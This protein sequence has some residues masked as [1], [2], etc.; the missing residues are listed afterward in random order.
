MFALT[1][2]QPWALWICHF[3]K[4]IENRVWRPPQNVI[5]QTIAIHAGKTESLTGDEIASALE[6]VDERKLGEANDEKIWRRQ[7]DGG[8]KFSAG[9]MPLR[10]CPSGA[11]VAVARLASVVA[12]S[13]DPW[14]VGPFG[15]VL[16]DVRVIEPVPCRGQQGLWELPPAVLATVR[17]R[18]LAAGAQ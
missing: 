9:P 2:K 12:A 1:I 15:W 18:W 14:F 10:E 7:Q 5:G 6:F 4:R 8:Y 16:D 13:D 11:I 17:E 3:G